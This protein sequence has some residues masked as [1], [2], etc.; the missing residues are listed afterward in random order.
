VQPL[1]LALLDASGYKNR[2]VY[3]GYS[4]HIWEQ[5]LGL[6]EK[7]F[8]VGGKPLTQAELMER[9]MR[10]RAE[11][12]TVCTVL[13]GSSDEEHAMVGSCLLRWQPLVSGCS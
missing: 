3:F 10:V 6:P 11:K 13:G 7:V 4:N 12:D 8:L 9:T 1:S 5:H 2:L